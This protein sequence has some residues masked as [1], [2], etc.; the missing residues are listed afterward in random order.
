MM[1]IF[2]GAD[3]SGKSSVIQQITLDLDTEFERIEYFHL[4]PALF[5]KKSAK[6]VGVMVKDPHSKAPY[7]MLKSIVKLIYL[8]VVYTIGYWLNRSDIHSS[9]VLVIFDRY[10]HDLLADPLRYRYSGS[11]RLARFVGKLMPAAHL[12][13][14]LD[15]SPDILLSRKQEVSPNE[16]TRQCK[17]Y[18]QLISALPT[19]RLINAEQP[20]EN[21]V[22]N[23]KQL[24][25]ETRES[26]G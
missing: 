21:V 1:V 4:K 23:T 2:L 26:L 11:L 7:S 8:L 5:G 9:K 17:A 10:Y 16:V 13:L 24:I 20:L 22:E 14:L 18:R 6:K 12:T 19:G 15:A 3:G 25:L